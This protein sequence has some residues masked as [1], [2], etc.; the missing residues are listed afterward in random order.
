[1]AG[2]T[3]FLSFVEGNE[4]NESRIKHSGGETFLKYIE[5]DDKG[6]RHLLEHQTVT[7]ILDADWL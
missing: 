1:V 3:G 2:E 6:R 7:R 4:E 5:S